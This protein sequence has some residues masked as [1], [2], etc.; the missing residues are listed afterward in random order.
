MIIRQ[1]SLDKTLI[2]KPVNKIISLVPS[3]SW[4]LFDLQLQNQIIGLSKFCKAP[5]NQQISYLKVGGTKNPDL[6]KICT[7]KPDLIIANIE[8]NRKEDVDQLAEKFTV[9]LSDVKD[10]NSMFQMMMDVSELTDRLIIGIDI[11]NRIKDKHSSYTQRP[12]WDINLPVVYLIWKNPLMTIGQ[13]TFIHHM[14]TMAGLQNCFKNNTRY[15]VI[16]LEE[17][18]AFHNPQIL[19]SSEPYPFKKKDFTD[20]NDLKCC[21][22]DGR[23]FSWYG[24]LI[25]QSFD[26]LDT[27]KIKLMTQYE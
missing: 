2:K 13:D 19:L 24:S 15:P 22:V 8:E 12:I 1:S 14:L 17:I 9:Y 6:Q 5:Y 10:L 4:F 27:L 3:I 16:T 20:F 26:Y 18:N 23:I 25:L 21:L 7:L 11:I